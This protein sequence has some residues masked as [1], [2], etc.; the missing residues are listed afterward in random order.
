M[1]LA[2]L[3]SNPKFHLLVNQSDLEY[4]GWQSNPNDNFPYL[5]TLVGN[6]KIFKQISYFSGYPIILSE[7]RKKI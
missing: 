3:G 2:W 7:D 1:K 4:Y 6:E 5:L